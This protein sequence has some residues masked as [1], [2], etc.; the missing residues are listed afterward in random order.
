MYN[1][2]TQVQIPRDA[3]L[4]SYYLKIKS[5]LGLHLPYSFQKNKV[6]EI[7][8]FKLECHNSIYLCTKQFKH[9]KGNDLISSLRKKRFFLYVRLILIESKKANK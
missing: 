7:C 9:A 5:L 1:P 6:K 4:D 2:A 8:S 3:N